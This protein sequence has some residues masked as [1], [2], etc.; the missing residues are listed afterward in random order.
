MVVNICS[1][2]GIALGNP[3]VPS[4]NTAGAFVFIDRSKF[5]KLIFSTKFEPFFRHFQTEHMLEFHICKEY[6]SKGF[7]AKHFPQVWM[8]INFW[9][10]NLV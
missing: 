9:L 3:Q 6:W 8:T 7:Y 10:I 1:A 5:Q 4:S 2:I